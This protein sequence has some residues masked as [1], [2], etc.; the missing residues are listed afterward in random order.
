MTSWPSRLLKKTSPPICAEDPGEA[1]E[2]RRGRAVRG[3]SEARIGQK[4]KLIHCRWARRGTRPRA[5]RDQRTEWAYIFGAICPAKG[6]GATASSSCPGGDGRRRWRRSAHRDSVPPSI[7]APRRV[8]IVDQGR[9]ALDAQAARSPTT[10]PSW[11]CRHDRS[12]L[13][14]VENVWQ[15]MLRQLVVEPD[16]QIL[17]RHPSR[18]ACQ[19]WSNLIDQPWKIDVPRHARMGASVLINDRWY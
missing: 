13:N 18:C 1:A 16:L 15:F 2:R 19:A 11:R 17:R 8:L 3:K 5:S 7:P 10:S 12:E 9:L 4:N 6:K 14:P